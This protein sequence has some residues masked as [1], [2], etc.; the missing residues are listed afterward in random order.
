MTWWITD[1]DPQYAHLLNPRPTETDGVYVT[2]CSIAAGF[3]WRYGNQ[4]RFPP[5]CASCADLYA[6][7]MQ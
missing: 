6:M 5:K 1:Q 7:S 3:W 4:G 2:L